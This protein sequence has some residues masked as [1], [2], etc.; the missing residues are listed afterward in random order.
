MKSTSMCMPQRPVAQT[1]D[2]GPRLAGLKGVLSIVPAWRA[3]VLGWP[4]DTLRNQGTLQFHKRRHIFTLP[5]GN[6]EPHL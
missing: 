2:P 5:K 3:A 6:T 1:A 4:R